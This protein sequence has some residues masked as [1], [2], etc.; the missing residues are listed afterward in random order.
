MWITEEGCRDPCFFLIP[1]RQVTDQFPVAENLTVEKFLH[2]FQEKGEITFRF[3]V[4]YGCERKILFG[5]EEIDQEALI[6]E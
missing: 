5:C 4:D 1:F 2:G 3:V 6:E